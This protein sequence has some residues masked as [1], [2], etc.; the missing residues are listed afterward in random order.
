MSSGSLEGVFAENTKVAPINMDL[1][2]N[3]FAIR[4]IKREELENPQEKELKE[5]K[6][7]MS[8]E[9]STPQPK[10]LEEEKLALRMVR[11]LVLKHH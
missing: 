8:H 11:C 3:V 9:Q 5:L 2:R 6:V 1:G 4:D 10:E 7:V